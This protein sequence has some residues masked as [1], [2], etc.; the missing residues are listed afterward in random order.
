M[1]D[2]L[3]E[4]KGCVLFVA[5][6]VFVV[7]YVV[8][9]PGNFQSLITKSNDNLIVTEVNVIDVLRVDPH[10]VNAT[11]EKMASPKSTEALCKTI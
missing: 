6:I 3:W 2:F 9:R 10:D 11:I 1:L 4:N 5:F 7:L 8:G